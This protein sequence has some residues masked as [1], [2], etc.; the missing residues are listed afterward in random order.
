MMGHNR[1]T[2]FEPA[3]KLVVRTHRN[4][5]TGAVLLVEWFVML[6]SG[7]P[8]EYGTADDRETAKTRG[9]AALDQCHAAARDAF[10]HPLT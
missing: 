10:P 7:F 8:V 2:L 4:T 3:M 5:R 1:P 6:D 9:R